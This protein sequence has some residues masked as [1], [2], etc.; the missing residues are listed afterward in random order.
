MSTARKHKPTP[1]HMRAKARR[2]H[3]AFNPI[4]LAVVRQRILA[5]IDS[6][7]TAAGLQAFIGGDSPTVV[8][9]LGR[10]VYIVCAAAG[11]HGL[12]NSPEASILAGTA[13][14]LADLAE[15]PESLE[16][17]RNTLIAGLA[18]I[19]RLMPK[20]SA[21]ALVYGAIRLDHLL[22]NT[23]GMSTSDVRTALTETVIDIKISST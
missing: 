9:L 15:Q 16:K 7:R 21:A 17:Q 1:K 11:Q 23:A 18:A 3:I 12:G 14:A 19:D 20:L 2:D 4:T 6:L 10:T 8:N 5:D 13:G 22:A